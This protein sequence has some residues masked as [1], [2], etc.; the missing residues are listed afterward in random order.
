MLTVEVSARP[1]KLISPDPLRLV[2]M[3]FAS[4]RPC[5][6]PEPLSFNFIAPAVKPFSIFTSP[7]PVR[8]IAFRSF[9]TT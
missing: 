5:R 6:S 4:I 7:D 9:A 1:D 2:S 8:L 3:V